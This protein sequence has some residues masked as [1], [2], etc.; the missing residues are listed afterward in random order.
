MDGHLKAKN[1][2]CLLWVDTHPDLN[3]NR[4]SYSGNIH[5]MSMALLA[6][7]LSEYWPNLPGMEWQNP[8]IPLR[9]LAYIGSVNSF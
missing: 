9:N 7:E 6:S 1:D 5:G 8:T 2:V 4:T 3:T